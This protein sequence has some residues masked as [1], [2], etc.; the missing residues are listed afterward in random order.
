[1]AGVRDRPA[2]RSKRALSVAAHRKRKKK[3]RKRRGGKVKRR[4]PSESTRAERVANE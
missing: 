3:E 4:K 1:M 2:P